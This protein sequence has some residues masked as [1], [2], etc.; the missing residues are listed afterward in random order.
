[1]KLL[2]KTTALLLALICGLTCMSFSAGAK[3]TKT[4]NITIHRY[5]QK[6]Y[7][8]KKTSEQQKY[9]FDYSVSGNSKNSIKVKFSDW[10]ISYNLE[11]KG[12]KIT[13]QKLPVISVFYKKGNTKVIVNKYKVTV[14]KK[15]K[16]NFK[17]VKINKDTNKTLKLYNPYYKDYYFKL[18]NP[19]IVK[20]DM[21]YSASGTKYSYD[22]KGDKKGTTNVDVYL[23][24]LKVKVGSFKIQVGNFPT[25]VKKSCK[26]IKLKYSS[27]GSNAYM[28]KSH[29]VLSD[30][31]KD[32]KAESKAKYSVESG[33][34]KVV[35]SLSSGEVYATGKG[36][37]T[38]TVYEKIGKA[39]KKAIDKFTVTVTKAN[40]AYVAE[41]NSMWYDEGIF[42]QGE[43]IEFLNLTDN[44]S[45]NMEATI[46]RCLINNS[47]TG[48][49]F[50]SSQ[51]EITYK[52][53]DTAIATVNSSGVVTARSLGSAYLRYIIIFE[54]GSKYMGRVEVCVESE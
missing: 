30:I 29:V 45:L 14:D 31:L 25:T 50:N 19:K 18:S 17:D 20:I 11:V 15:E 12:A 34:E 53:L 36:K 23:K 41:E 49:N 13:S 4:N 28:S 37:T 5:S 26:N 38:C 52:S 33:N 2:R 46:E 24:D 47:N 21:A 43:G 1:M 54:D 44:T 9:T 32:M 39:K 7:T 48:S 16:V 42:G 27:H 6:E 40:M 8:V 3:S 10:G 51:Y 22:T 35:S